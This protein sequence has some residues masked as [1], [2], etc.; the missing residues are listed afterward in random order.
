[1]EIEILYAA[2]L[3]PPVLFFPKKKSL[4]LLCQYLYF[5]TTSKARKIEYAR[6]NWHTWRNVVCVSIC[7]FVRAKQEKLS[8]LAYLAYDVERQLRH[9]ALE[10]LVYEALSY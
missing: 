4:R 8:T 6:K 9:D 10:L 7:T 1:M 3:G 5:C 2:P